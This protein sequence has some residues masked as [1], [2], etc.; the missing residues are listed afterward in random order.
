MDRPET[1]RQTTTVSVIIPAYNQA[2]YVSQAIQSVLDQTYPN[3]ELI[4]V[5]DGSTDESPK[6][7]AGIQDP[8][9]RVI[10]QPNAGLS[11]ARN[12]G[13]RVSSAP[14]ITLLDADDYFFPDKLA[15]LSAF[16]E[17]HP[18]IGMVSG[19][20]Q[21]VNQ[22]GE[23][24]RQF[25]KSPTSLKL[26]ELLLGN[27]FVPTAVMF[28]KQWIDRVGLFDEALRAC[29]DWDLWLRMASAGCQFAWVEHIVVA[30]RYHQGQMTRESARMRKAIITVL[31][32]FFSQPDL[33]ENLQA[34]IN[35]ANATG[36]IHAA[37]FAYHSIEYEKGQLDLSEA[38]RLDPALK[39]NH[40][41]RLVKFL[42][43]WSNDPRSTDPASFLQ[44]IILHPPSEQPGLSG[45]L[46]RA[47]ADIYLGSLFNSSPE[48]RRKHRRELL[49]AIRY[50]PE[51]LLNRGVLRMIIDAWIK[52]R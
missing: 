11:A 27:P 21:I 48:D 26:P 10:S 13:L 28:R 16:L 4:V 9:L 46:R 42:V 51:C 47:L 34:F 12:T 6:I 50:K 18:E 7:L 36:L 39:D 2:L 19:G 49:K 1:D 45:Q 22:A 32:K 38:V 29:E 23:T 35:I 41:E 30:Y 40:Y 33:P 15:V 44:T 24:L 25:V 3:F 52:P 8:R 17:A 31:D 20:Y 5:D 14:L 43:G 37:S